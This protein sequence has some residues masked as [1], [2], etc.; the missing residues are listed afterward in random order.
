MKELIKIEQR[1]GQ[2]AVNARDLHCYLQSKQDFSAWIRGR[3]SKYG[4][5]ENADYLKSHYDYKGN[6]LNISHDKISETVNQTHTIEYIISM[7]MAK[8]LSMVENND[9]GREARK[10]FIAVEKEAMSIKLPAVPKSFAEA[11]ELA[12]RQQRE[13]EAKTI[14]IELAENTIKES[15]PKV[16]YHDKVLQSTEGI[17]TTIIAKDL[18]MSAER[19]NE[20]LHKHGVIYKSQ[21]TWVLYHQYQDRGYT[22]TKTHHYIDSYGKDQAQIQTYW[23]EVGR[24]FIM[25]GIAKVGAKEL[26]LKF[27]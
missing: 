3:I 14:Q 27:K 6:L 16:E 2:R 7:D 12:A 23:T 5:I 8:E 9:K 20:I 21:K 25:E 4:F 17:T 26:S 1:N 11:L 15:A 24:K 19:L 22:V 13:I 18:G 10:Y